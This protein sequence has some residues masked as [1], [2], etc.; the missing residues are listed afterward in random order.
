ME[1][2]EMVQVGKDLLVE[3]D[4]ILVRVL[5]GV[6][7]GLEV[8]VITIILGLLPQEDREFFPP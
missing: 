2:V 7:V 5:E 4:F 6:A 1:L 3:T 8:L